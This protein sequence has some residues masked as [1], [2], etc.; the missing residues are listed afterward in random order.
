MTSR[1][2]VIGTGYV[3]LTTGAYLAHLGHDVVCADVVPEKIAMLSKGKLPIYEPGL[4]ELVRE[5]IDAGR[6]TFVLGAATAVHDA[7]FVFLCVQTPQGEDGSADMTY[8]RDAA[9][10]IGPVVPREAIVINKSTV[11]VGSTRVVEQAMGRDD[12]SVVSNPEFLRE[13]SAVHDCLNPDRI[14][15]GSEDQAAAMRVAKLFESLKAPLVITDPASA[16]TIKY[17]SNAFLASKVSFVN[18]LAHVCEAVGADVRE[19]VLGMGYDKR[20]GFEF[21]RPGPGWGGSCF[22]PEETLLVRRDGRTRLLSF[23][24]LFAAVGEEGPSGWEA[25]SWRP[26]EARPEFL[27]ISAFTKRPYE[28]DVVEIRTKMGRRVTVTADHPVVVCDGL[29]EESADRCEPVLAGEVTTDHWVPIAQGYP[30]VLDDPLVLGTPP[31]SNQP[32]ENPL[33]AEIDVDCHFWRMIG[34]YLAEGHTS[35]HHVVW[36]FN[37]TGEEDLVEQ[38]ASY[39]RAAGMRVTVKDRPTARAVIVHSIRLA[40]FFDALGLGRNCYEKAVPDRIWDRSQMEKWA[41]LRGLWDGDGSW[42]YINGGPS[43]IMEYGTASKRL[44]DG[45]LRLLG[46]LGIVASQRIGRTTKSTVDTHWLRIS[47]ADQ[48]EQA[49]KL[50]PVEESDEHSASIVR[51][52]KR[53]APTG[54]RMLSKNAAWVRVVGTARRPYGGDVYSVHVPGSETVVTTAGLVLH[55]CFPKDTRAL[56]KIA[57]DAGYDF[58]LLRGVISVNEEQYERMATKVEQMAGGSLE[59]KVI[60]AWGLAFKARTDDLRDSPAIEVIRRLQQRGAT[61]RAYDPAITESRP[62]LEGIDVHL[63]PYGPCEGADV[64]VVLT[65]WDEFRWLDFAKVA[66]V[67]ATPRVVDTRNLLEPPLVRRRGFQ[68]EGVGRS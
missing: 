31:A 59:G 23:E 50:F 6:L 2:A 39:W 1:I 29:D 34:L 3:G 13:G 62:A 19:V 7:E 68:Y 55:Q 44:A 46:D 40:R 27:P 66:G 52:S 33:P 54:Y 21:L 61:V 37:H 45:M 51:Q 57:E 26:M 9:A 8:V 11:P 30:L 18:A 25:L 67:M 12:V 53:I 35:E 49:W 58:D 42:S 41:L 43:V 32:H 28:G 64:L 15:I 20:I 48:I 65:E 5:G 24:E 63:D 22:L 36:S 4:E 60:A 47:G 17:A 16:E 14:V 10:E 38:I 56:V